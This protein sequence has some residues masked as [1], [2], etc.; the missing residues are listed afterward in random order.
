MSENAANSCSTPITSAIQPQV[1]RPLRMYVAFSVKNLE[2]P[3][4]AIP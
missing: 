4:A 3:I 2:S 1:F